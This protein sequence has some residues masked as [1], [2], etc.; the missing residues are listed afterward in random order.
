MLERLLDLLREGGTHRVIDLARR[1]ETTPELVEMM[2]EDL[3]RMGHLRP[4][5]GGCAGRCAT[6]PL[7]RVCAAG[8]G[9]RVWTLAER[10]GEDAG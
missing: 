1:L 3:A 8:A 4:V 7:A 9:A 2:L 10:S 5:S 6:C